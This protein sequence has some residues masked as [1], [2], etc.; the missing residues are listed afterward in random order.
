MRVANLFLKIAIAELKCFKD[1]I[2]DAAQIDAHGCL[3][4]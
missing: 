2:R 3:S 4:I 1:N